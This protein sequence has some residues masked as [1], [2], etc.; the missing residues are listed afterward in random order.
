MKKIILITAI[1]VLCAISGYATSTVTPTVTQ[2]LIPTPELTCGVIGVDWEG[3]TLN[4]AFSKR[5]L[6]GFLY[7]DEYLWVIGGADFTYPHLKDVWRSSNGADWELVTGNAA[8]G[9][10]AGHASVVY[11][12]RMWVIGGSSNG[13]FQNDVYWSTDGAV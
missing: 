9:E 11:N 13:S 5:H 8:F 10:L 1:I 7:Y 3:A 6:H 12:G 2:T 4:A